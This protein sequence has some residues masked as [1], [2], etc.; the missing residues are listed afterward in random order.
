MSFVTTAISKRS[1]RRLH[2]ASTSAV[3]PEPTGPPTPSRKTSAGCAPRSG[4]MALFT[5]ASVH[6]QII[7]NA[8]R[9]LARLEHRRDDQIRAAHHVPAREHLGIGGLERSI[10]CRAHAHAT[11]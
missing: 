2:S 9:G 3:F 11:A 10:R 6:A 7:E 5:L 4:L 8:P 1:R